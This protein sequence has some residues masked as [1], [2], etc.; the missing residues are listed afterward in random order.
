MHTIWST[1]C[2]ENS[3]A[4][5]S[6]YHL[7]HFR[8]SQELPEKK[9]AAHYVTVPSPAPQAESFKYCITMLGIYQ[10]YF[11]FFSGGMHAVY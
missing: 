3:R 4:A 5:A 8:L 6:S 7:S 10:N 11:F 2:T 9:W 1:L